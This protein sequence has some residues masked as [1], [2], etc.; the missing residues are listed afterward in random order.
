MR[1]GFA[2]G[3]GLMLAGGVLT[4]F[5]DVALKKSQSWDR[6]FLLGLVIYSSTAVTTTLGYKRLSFGSV[7][8]IWEAVVVLTSVALAVVLYGERMSL[9]KAAAMA[10]ALASVAVLA[11]DVGGANGPAVK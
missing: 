4:L 5:A 10:L 8:I 2:A 9:P 1:S 6:W 11:L 3:L 7:A